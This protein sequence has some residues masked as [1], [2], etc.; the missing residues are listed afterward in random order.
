VAKKRKRKDKDREK[1]KS[2]TQ[3]RKRLADTAD[4]FALYEAAVQEASLEVDF[5]L[6]AWSDFFGSPVTHLREDFCGSAWICA[7]WVKSDAAREA[8]GVDLEPSVLEWGRKRHIEPLGKMAERVRLLQEN[9]LEVD[10]GPADIIAA[11]NYSYF[12]FKTRE[13]LRAYFRRAW[14]GLKAEGL[15]VI[16]AYGGSDAQVVLKERRK[17]E[18]FSYVW[19]QADYNPINNDVTNHIHFHFPDGSKIKKAFTY[20]WRLWQIA[21]LRELILEAGFDQAIV[22]WDEEDEDGDSTGRWVPVFDADNDPGWNA[23]IIGVK[24]RG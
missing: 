24:R 14:E 2:K 22:F 9:V 6:Q 12:I 10:P 3:K 15:L 20:E 11:L 7:E 8:V 5:M 18:G 13:H 21:E 16:D 19:E 23:Y 4:K 1:R 17:C